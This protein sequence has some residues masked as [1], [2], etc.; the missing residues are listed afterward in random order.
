[1][2]RIC[3]IIVIFSFFSCKDNKLEE[4][5]AKVYELEEELRGIEYQ[6]KTAEEAERIPLYNQYDN[7]L[8]DNVDYENNIIDGT[9]PFETSRVRYIRLKGILTSNVAFTGEVLNGSLYIR[10]IDPYGGVVS[11]AASFSKTNGAML[12][13]TNKE[14]INSSSSNIPVQLAWGNNS[15]SI[16]S[17]AGTYTIELWFDRDDNNKASLLCEKTFKVY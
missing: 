15:Y 6:K 7:F 1:M 17:Y 2:K 13:Y 4:S 8:I 14:E 9:G 11:G 16:Y 10:Y 5:E 3:I 12:P